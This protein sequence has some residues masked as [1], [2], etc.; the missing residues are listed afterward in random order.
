MAALASI[1]PPETITP[2]LAP[3]EMRVLP[4]IKAASAADPEGSI[5]RAYSFHNRRTALRIPSMRQRTHRPNLVHR[6]RR[7]L[8]IAP[9]DRA[10][11]DSLF[12]AHKLSREFSSDAPHKRHPNRGCHLTQ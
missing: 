2:T 7:S 10:A 6:Q 8:P 3:S 1:F 4:S 9:V 11:P 5:S 12:Q